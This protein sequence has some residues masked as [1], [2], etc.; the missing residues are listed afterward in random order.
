MSA[1]ELR[2]WWPKGQHV[3]PLAAGATGP[4]GLDPGV[5]LAHPRPEWLAKQRRWEASAVGE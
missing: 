5:M 1:R 4:P 3:G 2:L